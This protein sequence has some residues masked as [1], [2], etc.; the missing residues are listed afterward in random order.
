[1]E[2]VCEDECEGYGDM[3]VLF[4]VIEVF[5]EVSYEDVVI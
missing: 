4:R 3:G 1:M 2:G 5:E